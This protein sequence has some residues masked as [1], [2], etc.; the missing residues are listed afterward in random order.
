MA[1]E[2]V[3]RGVGEGDKYEERDYALLETKRKRFFPLLK[4]K[5]L[6]SNSDFYSEELKTST[7]YPESHSQKHRSAASTSSFVF[8]QTVT[9]V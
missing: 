7:K 5:H 9:C 6:F 1:S 2:A 8:S 4:D 3:V